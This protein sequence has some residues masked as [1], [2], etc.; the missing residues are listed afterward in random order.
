[1]RYVLTP[2]ERALGLLELYA[3]DRQAERDLRRAMRAE[4]CKH[5]AADQDEPRCYVVSPG[6]ETNCQPCVRR[7]ELW[8]K[9]RL[10]RQSNRRMLARLERL[11]LRLSAPDPDPPP[12]PKPLLDLMGEGAPTEET[13]TNG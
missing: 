10:V 6:A 1:V 7:T 4:R 12:D 5:A 8:R 11:A 9:Y 13:R 2:A 3:V